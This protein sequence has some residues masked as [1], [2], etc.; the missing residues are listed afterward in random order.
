MAQRVDVDEAPVA[1][2]VEEVGELHAI[3]IM[4]AIMAWEKYKTRRARLQD[5][6]LPVA[7]RVE[8]FGN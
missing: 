4:L 6:T 1:P 3:I 2:Y 5:D 8:R 7:R